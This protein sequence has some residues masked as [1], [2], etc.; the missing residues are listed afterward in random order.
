M[1]IWGILS[2]WTI[3]FKVHWNGEFLAY[4][5]YFLL[6][7]KIKNEMKHKNVL[8]CFILGVIFLIMNYYL[9]I[10]FKNYIDISIVNN[11]FNHRLSLLNVI[12][13]VYIFRGF[14]NLKINKNLF[15]IAEKTYLIYLFHII[16]LII[17]A[18][19]LN[20]CKYEATNLIDIF[21]IFGI[22][23][24]IYVLSHITS[25]IYEKCEIIIKNI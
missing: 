14:C 10:L 25:I 20:I 23:C 21:M 24:L 8:K 9:Y 6:E 4:I 1:V 5:G 13:S 18:R 2:I 11:L 15:F 12:A 22:S 19:F 7:Y 17:I 3:E 16:F